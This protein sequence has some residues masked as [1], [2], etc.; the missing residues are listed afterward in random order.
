VATSVLTGGDSALKLLL[1]GSTWAGGL[2]ANLTIINSGTAPLAD[3]SLSFESDVQITGA[4]WGLSFTVSKLS[5]GHYSYTL[6]GRD[7]GAALAP[8]AS[9]T[10]GFNATQASTAS[11]GTLQPSTLFVTSPLALVVQ[12]GPSNPV[13]PIAP[14]VAPV[15]APPVAGPGSA[16]T[17]ELNPTSF[18][19]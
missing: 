3:W 2:T 4:P 15:V 14:V 12:S 16:S 9:V 6:A 8:G 10:V 18:A 7:W 17:A 1:D 13:S 19:V 11:T 5:N